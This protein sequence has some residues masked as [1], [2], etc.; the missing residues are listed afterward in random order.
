M[1]P[2]A[3]TAYQR[4]V[5]SDVTEVASLLSQLAGVLGAFS[6]TAV[7]LLLE[8]FR[9]DSQLEGALAALMSSFMSLLVAA[10][11]YATVAGESGGTPRAY[12]LN[13]VAAIVIATGLL[14]MVNGLTHLLTAAWPTVFSGVVKLLVLAVPVTTL[15]YVDVAVLDLIGAIEGEKVSAGSV[16]VALAL[17]PTLLL[18]GVVGVIWAR[19]RALP[20]AFA[21][22]CGAG[23]QR[24]FERTVVLFLVA[25]IVTGALLS[26]LPEDLALPA[27]LVSLTPVL[28]AVALALYTVGL[29]SRVAPPVGAR[30]ATS[31]A[32]RSG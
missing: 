7:L 26:R 32:A 8:R 1:S 29:H 19:W 17:I 13:V 23:V 5:G 25:L 3:S 4:S 20:K 21:W 11:L 14:M 16:Y 9:R 31:A 18:A 15:A 24:A 10:F 30:A 12:A 27:V 22:A 28:F 6:F 2:L